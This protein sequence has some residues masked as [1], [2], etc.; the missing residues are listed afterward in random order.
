VRKLHETREGDIRV[1]TKVE[2]QTETK[3][4]RCCTA[5]CNADAGRGAPKSRREVFEESKKHRGEG[6]EGAAK[7]RNK[8]RKKERQRETDRSRERSLL[9][10]THNTQ[11][12]WGAKE[13]TR[14]NEESQ[15]YTEA[16]AERAQQRR[17]GIKRDRKKER[18]TERE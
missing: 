14:G 9:H 3:K 15:R 4:D 16:K 10:R 13:Q 12:T 1:F 6:R 7:K 17:G 11:T 5:Q 18:K 2:R 8:E